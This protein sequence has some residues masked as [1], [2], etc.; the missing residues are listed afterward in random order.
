MRKGNL[1]GKETEADRKSKK[2]KEKEGWRGDSPCSFPFPWL[3]LSDRR[4]SSKSKTIDFSKS[5][6]PS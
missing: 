3:L 5:Q 2:Q 4:L 6:K 1:K